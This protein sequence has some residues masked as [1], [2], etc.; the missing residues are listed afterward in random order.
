MASDHP[1]EP[2]ATASIPRL[3]KRLLNDGEALARAELRLAQAQATHQV[4]AAVPGL[5]A[6]LFGAI[7]VLASLFTLLAALIGW[8]TPVLG[9]GNAALVVTLGT[10][11]IG[12]VAIALGVRHLNNR[13]S[14]A[15][16][17]VEIK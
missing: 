4:R 1:R 8:L 6:I 11:A 2:D 7:F 5:V 9:A 17:E 15:P 14:S 10:A 3:V 13:A 16:A 12:G